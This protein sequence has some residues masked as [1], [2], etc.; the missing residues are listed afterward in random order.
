MDEFD[1]AERVGHLVAEHADGSGA[2]VRADAAWLSVRP[3][4]APLP[5]QGW[6]LHVSARIAHFPAVVDRLVPVLL[7][8]RC[9][10]KLARSSRA[11]ARLN[12]GVTT[13]SSVGKA[14][15]VYPDQNR[16]REIGLRLAEI[17]QGCEG[18]RVRS[19]RRVR[20]DA[21]VYY[22]YGPFSPPWTA[23]GQGN[24][25]SVLHGPGGE[26]FG[27]LATLRYRQPAWAVDPFTGQRGAPPER[28]DRPAEP[29]L[30]GD[31]YLVTAGVFRSGRGDV[32]R[33]V[34]Q[35]DGSR[36]IVKQARALVDEEISVD[37]PVDARMRVRN[38]RRVLT[39]LDGVPGVAAYVDHFRVGDDEYLVTRDVGDLNL[40]DDVA[41]NGRYLPAGAPGAVA[42]RGLEQLGRR[43]AR[44]LLD[45]HQRGV[46]IR[47]LHP[48]NIVVDGGGASLIDFGLAGY[49]GLHL[50]GGT[51]GYAAP[52][53]FTDAE[54]SP[55]DD[56]L[57]LGATL[58]FAWSGLTPVVA[59]LDADEPR[60]R[61]LQLLG[62][63][64]L[65]T[66]GSAADITGRP[67]EHG[68][69]AVAGRRVAV[70]AR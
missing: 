38:E 49:E 13:P 54:P 16:V 15:T 51:A 18:P 37:A 31:H 27:G 33:A 59:A 58:V 23:D 61:S 44:I 52:R 25:V 28:R 35:R 46:L 30:I 48:R 3:R 60:R 40:A 57:A 22:R 12:D 45:V 43:L 9:V 70:G 68:R 56:F 20:P 62:R 8:E 55:T 10:F 63:A 50:R 11:L 24:L 6:K 32:M 69:R 5:D 1:L 26:E 21:P 66:P 53:Q 7:A 14:V 39:V 64:P 42:G 47:D 36:V 34:D 19:D 2:V 65:R 17:L 67:D 4:G 29:V 41:R